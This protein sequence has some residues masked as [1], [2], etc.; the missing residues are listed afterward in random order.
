MKNVDLFLNHEIGL[1]LLRKVLMEDA[2]RMHVNSVVSPDV[3]ILK[4]ANPYF[5]VYQNYL[6]MD[7]TEGGVLLS[8]HYD[9][10]FT[11]EFL[12]AYKFSYNLHPS[13]LPYGKGRHPIFWA[14]YDHEPLGATLHRIDGGLDT[15]DVIE[16]V[17]VE[18][19]DYDTIDGYTAYR[20]VVEIQKQILCFTTLLELFVGLELKS[21]SQQGE[22]SFHKETDIYFIKHNDKSDKA[23]RCLYF[24]DT[25][26]NGKLITKE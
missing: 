7:A 15:G 22:G 8:V 3:A 18:N 19:V 23:K 26:I 9:R 21:H 2:L 1:W 25:T 11:P 24:P 14:I 17:Q 16:Q 13:Y 20:Q 10:K 12:R 5:D 4:E 6:E